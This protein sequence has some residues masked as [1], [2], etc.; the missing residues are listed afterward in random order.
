MGT[1]TKRHCICLSIEAVVE[2][3]GLRMAGCCQLGLTRL[4]TLPRI[5]LWGFTVSLSWYKYR[6]PKGTCFI[7]QVTCCS[8]LQPIS[9]MYAF[10]WS[11]KIVSNRFV[12]ITQRQRSSWAVFTYLTP[13]T[14]G[15][16]S[17]QEHFDEIVSKLPT[18]IFCRYTCWTSSRVVDGK[19]NS[20]RIWA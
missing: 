17:W 9:S 14:V 5:S 11:W 20:P 1:A 15:C 3:N 18:I 6:L 2:R 7:G 8:W 13:N 4:E 19:A 16:W 12:A 10:Y